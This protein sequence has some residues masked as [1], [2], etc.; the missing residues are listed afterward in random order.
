LGIL[1]ASSATSWQLQRD[2]AATLAA[3]RSRRCLPALEALAA[4][5]RAPLR[6]LEGH[7]GLAPALGARSMRF[8]PGETGPRTTLALGLA[9]FATLGLV[10]E[11]LVVVK[12]LF[13]R[14]EHKLCTAVHTLED[15]ILKFR[16]NWP[17]LTTLTTVLIEG[18]GAQK[19]PP[20]AAYST[21]RRVFFRFR[22]R[23]SACLARSFSP[24]F[25]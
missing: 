5:H 18:G 4:I 8:G 24:G 25:R 21:S 15:A 20:P 14:R 19:S 13:T 10:L 22:L 2:A 6:G 16:H 9:R 11:I 7:G 12:V 17:P 23:A 1:P 3:G